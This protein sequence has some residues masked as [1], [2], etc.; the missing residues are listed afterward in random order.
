MYQVASRRRSQP[1]PARFVFEA[2]VEPHREPAR[3]WLDLMEGET[4]P[5]IVRT[6][7]PELVIW[8]SIWRDR[9][10]AIIRFDIESIGN[11]TMLCWT[12]FV[13]DPIP[14][15]SEVVLM[16]RRLNVLINANLRFTFG[17]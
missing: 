3:H 1:P 4:E 12:L 7:D 11:N 9:P 5:E 10:D 13:D 16:R 14:S 8:S 2:L 6:V 17:Q 15:D